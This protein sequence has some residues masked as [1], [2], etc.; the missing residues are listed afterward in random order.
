[1]EP[2][3]HPPERHEQPKPD[4]LFHASA[5]R[6]IR[7]FEPRADKIRDPLEGPVVFA[8]PDKAYASCFLVPTDDSWVKIGRY[9]ADG[10]T[11]PW[12]VVINGEERFRQLDQGGT[13]YGLPSISFT[14]H[15]DRN[16]GETEWTSAEPVVPSTA[17]AFDSGLVAMQAQG[18]DVYFVDDKAF[19]GINESNDH[20]QSAI[21]SL[22]PVPV[23]P[24]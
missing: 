11:G 16:M 1:M 6:G 9:T 20:G 18:V 8:T 24:D 5:D 4:V 23:R 7:E 13:I 22:M 12:K 10:V 15:A 14:Y 2:K 3:P 17:E 19:Q 21:A